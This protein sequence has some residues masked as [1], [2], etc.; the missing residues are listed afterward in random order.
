MTA[1]RWRQV[2][3]IFNRAVEAEP[4]QR[5]QVLR[6]ACR[7][8]PELL[9]EVESLLVSD[10]AEGSVLQDNSILEAV[11]KAVHESGLPV[12]KDRYEIEREL[13]RGGM[14]LVYLARDRQLLGKR[15][16]VKVLLENSE[17]D[18]WIRQKFQQEMEA[19]ARIDHP[20][21]VGVLDS[22]YTPEGRQFLVMQYVQ[23]ETLRSILQRKEITPRRAAGLIRQIGQALAAAHEKGV[24]HRDLKPENVMVQTVDGEDRVKLIDFGI[25]GIQNSRFSGQKTRIAGTAGYMAPEQLAGQAVAESDIYALAV[26]ACEMLTGTLPRVPAELPQ[27]L[28]SGVREPLSKALSPTP[29]MRQTEVRDLSERLYSALGGTSGNIAASRLAPS[30]YKYSRLLVVLIALAILSPAIWYGRGRFGSSQRQASIAVLPFVD[31]SPEENQAYFSEGLAEELLNELSKVRGLRVAARM[32]SFRFAGKAED[33][34]MVGKKLNVATLLEGSVR[35]QTSRARISVRLIHAS[36]GLQ[37]W[38]DTYDTE[39]KDILSV[40]QQIAQA[41]AAEMKI[42]LLGGKAPPVKPVNAEAHNAYLQGRYLY[43]RRTKSNLEKATAY[44]EQAIRLDPQYANAWLLLAACR[45]GLADAGEL[46]AQQGFQMARQAV[47]QALKLDP[48]LAEA[49]S[50]LGW[51]Q[52]QWEWDWAGADASYKRALQLEPGNAHVLDGAASLAGVLGRFDEALDLYRRARE[53]DPLNSQALFNSAFP[54]YYAGRYD[55]ASAALSSALELVPEMV[56]VHGMLGRIWLAKAQPQKA[57][58][59][60]D[61]EKDPALRLFGLALAYDALGR[62][63]ESDAN[64]NELIQKFQ[65]DSPYQIALV[66]ARRGDANEAFR[67]LEKAYSTR[68]AGLNELKGDPLLNNLR[69]DPRFR[70]LLKKVG[71]AN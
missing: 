28:P 68:D 44:A 36:D 11:A 45:I 69:P 23:G 40:Q 1:D 63:G 3:D 32:S 6:Q 48:N 30:G 39:L 53:A 10:E 31:L 51:I 59:E 12:L 67:W 33:S 24:W 35:K 21:V 17:S 70:G 27:G 58:A 64:L 56:G 66:Y 8:D 38:S 37:L 41:V 55:H 25:A 20:A 18:P 19:L 29:A 9:R 42:A 26:L 7:G 22:G 47:N 50:A 13:G 54:A 65:A 49:Y 71:L 4:A 34:A 52:M 2:K 16:V 60:M 61:K 14:S 46:P 5:E 43:E 15:V 57:L 62:R